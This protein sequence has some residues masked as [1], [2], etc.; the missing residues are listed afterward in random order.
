M[1]EISKKTLAM[2]FLITLLS[3]SVLTPVLYYTS[4]IIRGEN[5]IIVVI[6][7]PRMEEIGWNLNN[8]QINILEKQ[9]GEFWRVQ[10]LNLAANWNWDIFFYY[11]ENFN[12]NR[13]RYNTLLIV[14]EGHQTNEDS[15]TLRISDNQKVRIESLAN[16][17]R[18]NN[19]TLIVDACFSYR[20]NELF[21]HPNINS[22]YTS[23]L[24]NEPS[25]VIFYYQGGTVW[26]ETVSFLKVD[27]YNYFFIKQLL[28]GDNYMAANTSAITQAYLKNLTYIK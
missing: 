25:Y 14:F 7:E 8:E 20:W 24:E 10:S 28:N 17:V 21:L 2:G 1:V 27:S 18:C 22:I 4:Y 26:N 13:F 3:I 16:Q 15:P 12:L 5:A 19:L 9:Y 6:G 11:R 23:D